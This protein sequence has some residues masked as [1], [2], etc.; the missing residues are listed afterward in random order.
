MVFPRKEAVVIISDRSHDEKY[1]SSYV[2]TQ[3]I[4]IHQRHNDGDKKY[5]RNSD[6]HR[7]F[8]FPGFDNFV[9]Q[10]NVPRK[11]CCSLSHLLRSQIFNDTHSLMLLPA[12][13]SKNMPR[14]FDFEGADLVPLKSVNLVWPDLS[15]SPIF[16][17]SV[18]GLTAQW[19]PDFGKVKIGAPQKIRI[20]IPGMTDFINLDVKYSK[21]TAQSV[22]LSFENITSE[23]RLVLQQ[24]LKD[25]MVIDN[26]SLKNTQN[27]FPG[28]RADVWLHGPYDT[29]IM[30]WRE[31]EEIVQAV[32]EYDNLQWIYE[33][34]EILLQKSKNTAGE[35][36]GYFGS[37]VGAPVVMG[38][39]WPDRLLR[40]LAKI[41]QKFPEVEGVAN[42]FREERS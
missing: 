31:G 30:L 13:T 36:K 9:L 22:G 15:R 34:G 2:K 20:E 42:L 3:L 7:Q 23:G 4:G 27:L 11:L 35:S 18:A 32:L 16:D 19:V 17:L 14:L 8:L 28:L 38:A 37:K 26:V 24:V 39:S 33:D 6:S 25:Q 21:F 12:L 41:E 10:V 29:N 5:P 40:M 1:S